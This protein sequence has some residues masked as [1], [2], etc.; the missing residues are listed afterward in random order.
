M[1]LFSNF[2]QNWISSSLLSVTLLGSLTLGATDAK[3]IDFTDVYS[4][5]N[6]TTEQTAYET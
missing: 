3:A 5:Y 6:W 2:R 4:P 1:L